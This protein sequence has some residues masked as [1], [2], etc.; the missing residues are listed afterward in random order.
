MSDINDYLR[1]FNSS[2]AQTSSPNQAMRTVFQAFLGEAGRRALAGINNR[3]LGKTD[4][5]FVAGVLQAGTD[6]T[7]GIAVN[8]ALSYVIDGKLYAGTASTNIPIPAALGTQGT[9]SWCKYLLSLGTAGTYTI[10][11]GN[12]STSGSAGAFL[13]DLPD[14][15]VAVGYM[16]IKTVASKFTAGVGDPA[17]NS[18]TVGYYDL[19]SMPITEH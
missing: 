19:M 17:G 9:A 15:N 16:T 14:E 18:A 5:T 8:N 11:K 2:Y 10:T 6:G 13:P 4:G 1:K 3:V 7:P 12:E